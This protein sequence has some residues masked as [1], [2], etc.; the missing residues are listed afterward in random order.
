MLII[1]IN[2]D[3]YIKELIKNILGNK[4]IIE[5]INERIKKEFN[6]NKDDVLYDLFSQ[7]DFIKSYD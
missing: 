5:M 2:N 3:N 1:E 7:K 4:N 6:K